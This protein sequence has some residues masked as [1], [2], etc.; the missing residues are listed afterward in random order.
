MIITTG[1]E[2]MFQKLKH[3]PRGVGWGGRWEGGSEGGDMYTPMVDSSRCMAETNK[4]CKAIMLELKV[5]KNLKYQ[6][7]HNRKI[8]A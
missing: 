7:I 5:N 4:Y 1:A 2:N 3:S 8:R 6:N